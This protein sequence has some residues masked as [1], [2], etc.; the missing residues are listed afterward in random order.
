MAYSLIA[1]SSATVNDKR[2][3]R[4][5]HNAHDAPPHMLPAAAGARHV[6]VLQVLQRVVPQV[7]AR[8]HA[9]VVLRPVL[10]Q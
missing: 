2:K 8:R 5:R 1:L 4:R 7:Q 9:T 6:Q 3:V 10:H